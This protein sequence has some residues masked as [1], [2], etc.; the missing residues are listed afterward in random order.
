MNGETSLAEFK[1]DDKLAMD[2]L[3]AASYLQI[4]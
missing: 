2:V 4:E 1:I 3:I